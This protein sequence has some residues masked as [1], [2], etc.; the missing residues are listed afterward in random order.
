MKFIS[1]YSKGDGLSNSSSSGLVAAPKSIP[2]FKIT[3]MVNSN[4]VMEGRNLTFENTSANAVYYHW[5]FGNGIT[6]DGKTPPKDIFYIP[7]GGSSTITLTTKNIAGDVAVYSQSFNIL[8]S[9][10]NSHGQHLAD[11]S[12]ESIY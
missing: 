7:C 6:Y 4:Y 3:N 12:L 9:G 11:L 8:C 2:A 10:K 5:D 1:G